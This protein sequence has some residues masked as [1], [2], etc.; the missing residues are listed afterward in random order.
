M[1]AG[2]GASFTA[3]LLSPHS[4]SWR[5][6][7]ATTPPED[8]SFE[9]FLDL[10]GGNRTAGQVPDVVVVPLEL[11]DLRSRHCVDTAWTMI[12]FFAG[13]KLTS[14]RRRW[15][16]LLVS[17]RRFRASSAR[18]CLVCIVRAVSAGPT[19]YPDVNALLEALLTGLKD[20]L[21]TEFVGMYLY[22]SLASGE[23]N[24]ETS[25]VDFVVVT[26]D[27]LPHDTVRGVEAVHASILRSGGKWPRKL[28]GSY[29]PRPEL[30]RYRPD[31]PEIPQTHEGRFYLARHG[32]DWIIQR[33]V[34]R[35]HGVVVDGPPL[36]PLIDALRPAELRCAV[37]ATLREWWAPMLAD[38]ARLQ[39]AE[40]QAFAVLTMCRA[41]FTLA[42]GSVASK[43]VAARW[44]QTAFG[45]RWARLVEPA[46]VWREGQRLDRLSE[47][48]DF[49]RFVAAVSGSLSGSRI[50]DLIQT[51]RDQE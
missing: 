30:R 20:V 15:S 36:R 23:F 43:P 13:S 37:R 1:I 3:E 40:Y 8:R 41:L 42:H 50:R 27:L 18:R 16:A 7:G 34:L 45:D 22:G 44:V 6:I 21:G 9:Q 19:A 2:A 33:H 5:R 10:V 51:G 46:L 48:L 32:S 14:N 12:R 4:L 47:T 29:I 38:Q 31:G 11:D 26:K 24:P 49:V 35:E 28:E 17:P 39:S 25:D